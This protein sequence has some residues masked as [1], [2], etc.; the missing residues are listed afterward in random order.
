MVGQGRPCSSDNAFL[1]D[2]VARGDGLDQR[3]IAVGIDS[4]DFQII[5]ADA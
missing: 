1:G 4:V 5:D 2:S 3:R